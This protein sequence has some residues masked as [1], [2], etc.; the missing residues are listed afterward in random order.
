M[1]ERAG[2]EDIAS[3][4]T[5]RSCALVLPTLDIAVF[6]W[7]PKI[8][9][10]L[11]DRHTQPAIVVTRTAITSRLTHTTLRLWVPYEPEPTMPLDWDVNR[12]E[13]A[14]V[15]PYTRKDLRL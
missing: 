11:V 15:T 14:L 3:A 2:I 6:W 7:W 10:C 4:I 8:I 1:L 13:Y 9:R 5:Y 12:S